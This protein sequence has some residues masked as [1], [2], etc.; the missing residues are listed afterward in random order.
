M[1][2]DQLQ[3]VAAEVLERAA[4]EAGFWRPGQGAVVPDDLTAESR[5]LVMTLLGRREDVVEV[6][7]VLRDFFVRSRGKLSPREIN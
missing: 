1:G 5:Q 7:L 4:C 3:E 6:Y 2:E